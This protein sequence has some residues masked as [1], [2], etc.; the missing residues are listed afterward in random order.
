MIFRRKERTTP[1]KTSV[2][3]S[4]VIREQMTM[5]NDAA[6][7]AAKRQADLVHKL[8]QNTASN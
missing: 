1:K 8:E 5:V 6:L 3:N 4:T 7:G 2:K